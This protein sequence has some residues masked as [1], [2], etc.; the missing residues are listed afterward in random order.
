MQLSQ[1]DLPAGQ[2]GQTPVESAPVL[3]KDCR[4]L[5]DLMLA[6]LPSTGSSTSTPQGISQVLPGDME[7]PPSSPSV[8][9]VPNVLL[10]ATPS[11]KQPRKT[12]S[13]SS[14]RSPDLEVWSDPLPI[15]PPFLDPQ[16]LSAFSAATQMS[17]SVGETQGGWR[18]QKKKKKDKPPPPLV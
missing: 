5:L 1:E 2:P 7:V 15:S 8:P 9:N 3:A 16:S 13:D 17:S 18:N 10:E 11:C 6:D 14:T 4:D 12:S